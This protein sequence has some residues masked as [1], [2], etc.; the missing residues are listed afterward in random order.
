MKSKGLGSKLLSLLTIVALVLSFTTVSAF[1]A[2]NITLKKY[3][4]GAWTNITLDKE[5]Q[6]VPAGTYQAAPAGDI[7]IVKQAGFAIV[8]GATKMT[9]ELQTAILKV[10]S[11]IWDKNGSQKVSLYYAGDV[12]SYTVS[13]NNGGT[14]YFGYMYNGQKYVLAP[15]DKVSHF[16]TD[17]TTI[18]GGGTTE[19]TSKPDLTKKILVDGKEVDSDSVAAGQTVKFQLTSTLPNPLEGNL[20]TLTFHDRMANVFDTPTNFKVQIGDATLQNTDYTL[21]QKEFSDGCTFE[22]SMDLVALKKAGKFADRDL[23]HAKVVVTY[24]AT[25]KKDTKAGDYQNMSWVTYPDG[26]SEKDIVDVS[27]YAIQV[28]KYDADDSTKGL[29]GAVFTLKDNSGKIIGTVTTG[30]D[31]Y[32]KFDGLDEGTY[33]IEETKAPEGYTGSSDP[34]QIIISKDSAGDDYIVEYKAANKEIPHSGGTGTMFYTIGG[35]AIVIA[36]GALILVSRKSR[37]QQA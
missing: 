14:Y 13:D 34:K 9:D 32:A 24:E 8:F 36:A 29:V 23:G 19:K 2:D 33:M 30:K 37:K 26:E 27:T 10:D 11:S 35:V 7:A 18:P 22:I 12:S 16:D 1:A 20:Y 6:G 25:L 28:F 3:E 21:K 17:G 5:D 31:G 15:K 4:N